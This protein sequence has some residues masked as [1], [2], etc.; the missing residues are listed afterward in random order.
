MH[1]TLVVGL[2]ERIRNLDR[3][4]NRRL[5]RQRSLLEPIGERLAFDVLH[6]EEVDATLAAD[7]VERADVRM[8]Q[9]GNRTG[10]PLEALAGVWVAGHIRRQDF[11]RNGAVEA[12]V[13]RLVDL[14]HPTCTNGREDL[15]GS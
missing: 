3:M 9:T 6:D 1:H 13:S 2:I 8:V 7:V 4:A 5:D 14:S 10:F 11:D 15:V 12:S